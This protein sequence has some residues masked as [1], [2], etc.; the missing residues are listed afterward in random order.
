MFRQA[1][2]K[3]P[4]LFNA[5]NSCSSGTALHVG[6]LCL[7]CTG[8]H[9]CVQDDFYFEC[10]AEVTSWMEKH[11]K[12]WKSKITDEKGTKR[13]VTWL[14]D[15]LR[16]KDDAGVLAP[17]VPA[18]VS[19]HVSSGNGSLIEIMSTLRV[20][21]YEQ[22]RMAETAIQQATVEAE[23]EEA[24][25]YKHEATERRSQFKRLR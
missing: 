18:S 21:K 12:N 2:A 16:V 22:R 17:V 7:A 1:Q 5:P 15:M 24:P 19:S 4:D 6:R 20:P 10:L 13:K 8:G 25:R 9:V 23:P 14:N 11:R 3:R